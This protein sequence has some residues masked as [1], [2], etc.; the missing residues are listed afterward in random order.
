MHDAD[1]QCAVIESILQTQRG[2]LQFDENGGIDYFGTVLQNPNAIKFWAAQVTS[3]I[4]EL[5][6]V[7]SVEDFQYRFDAATSTLYWSMT[8]INTEDE[9]LDLQQKKTVLDGSPG[10]DVDWNNIYDKP[11]GTNEALAMIA[12]MRDEAQNLD[13]LNASSTLAK[14]KDVIDRVVYDPNDKDYAESRLVRF[15]FAG[16]PLGTVIDFSNMLLDLQDTGGRFVPFTVEISDGTKRRSLTNMDGSDLRAEGNN[17]WFIDETAEP[18]SEGHFPPTQ[19]HTIMSGG[20]VSITI[21]GNITGIKSADKTRPIFL[22]SDGSVFPYLSKFIVGERVPLIALGD[23]AFKGFKNL[24][25]ITWNEPDKSTYEISFGESTFEGCESLLGLSWLPYRL[26]TIGAKCFM[27]CKGI[28]GLSSVLKDKD[29]DN[30]TY[31]RGLSTTLVEAIPDSAFEGC[32]ALGSV[33]YLPPAI[34]SLGNRAFAKCSSLLDIDALPDTIKSLGVECFADCTGIQKILYMPTSLTAIGNGCFSGCTSLRSLFLPKDVAN[35]GSDAFAGDTSL[36]NVMCE[37]ETAPVIDESTFDQEKLDIY[38]PEGSLGRYKVANGW[39][40][41]WDDSTD[42]GTIYEYGTAEFRLDNVTAGTKL[43]AGTSS[44]VSDSIWSVEFRGTGTRPQRF[45]STV[46]AIPAFTFDEQPNDGITEGTAV[47]VV[48]GFIRRMSALTES[49]Y[50]MLAVSGKNSYLTE[51][52]LHLRTSLERIGD[53]AFAEC[54]NLKTVTTDSSTLPFCLGE[55][56]FWGCSSLTSMEWV[57]AFPN[58]GTLPESVETVY[59]L[60]EDGNIQY[61]DQGQP[62]TH[63]EYTYYPAFGEGCFCESGITALSYPTAHV[64]SLSANCFA[65]TK[66]ESLSGIESSVLTSIGEY[67]FNG[68]ENLNSIASLVNT[69]VTTIPA[70]CFADCTALENLDGIDNIAEIQKYAFRGCT[71]LSTIEA[72]SNAS[73]LS[74]LPAHCFEDCTSITTLKGIEKIVQLGEYTFAGCAGL[75]NLNWLEYASR[76]VDGEAV[77]L[78]TIPP[79]CFERCTGI[80]TLVGCYLVKDISEGAFADCTG[81]LSPSGLGPSIASIGERAFQ[82]CT[83]LQF[84][85][86]IA[87]SVPPLGSSAF[88]GVPVSSLTL[89]VRDGMENSFSGWGGFGNV[90]SRTIRV[91]Y[92]NLDGTSLNPSTVDY[93]KVTT[94]IKDGDSTIPG[95]WFIDYGDGTDIIKL[96]EI[97]GDETNPM[98]DKLVSHSYSARGA[99]DITLFGD[100]VD[101]RGADVSYSETAHSDLTSV[102]VPSFLYPIRQNA[103]SVYVSSPYLPKIG[104]FCYNGYGRSGAGLSVSVNIASNGTIGAYAFA[105][106]GAAIGTVVSCNATTIEP[107]AFYGSGLDSSSAFNFVI[108]T[109]KGAF[110]NNTGLP[111]LQGFSALQTLG[112]RTFEGCTALTTTTG[113]SSV[114]TI[115]ARAFSGCTGLVTVRDF[116]GSLTTIKES[117]FAGCE[118]ITTIFMALEN[119][120]TSDGKKWNAGGELAGD[121]FTDGVFDNALLYVPVETES[122]YAGTPAWKRFNSDAADGQ[123]RIRSRSVVF[124][125]KNITNGDTIPK[126]ACKVTATGSWTV[127][128]GSQQT[129]TYTAGTD[130]PVYA[131]T[132]NSPGTEDGSIDVKISGAVISIRG[133]KSQ[134]IFGDS[135]G[136]KLQSISSSSAMELATIGEGSFLN[137]D[138]LK[139]VTTA[140]SVQTLGE[141]AFMGAI[142]LT[143][144]SGLSGVSEIG[145][146]AFSGCSALTSLYGLSSV[147]TIGEYAF[148]GC[149]SLKKIDG[150][151]MGVTSIGEYAFRSCSSLEEIQM[152]AE[153]PPSIAATAFDDFTLPLYVRTKVIPEYSSAAVWSGFANI[154]SRYVEFTLTA[155]PANLTVAGEVGKIQSDTYWVVDWDSYNAD[156]QDSRSGEV[157]FLPE[158]VYTLSGNHTFRIEGAVTSISGD[159]DEEND[160]I[161]NEPTGE[162]EITGKSF[163]TLMLD[164]TEVTSTDHY[165]TRV[166]RSG[167]STLNTV[168]NAAFLHNE[169]LVVADLDGINQ[170][171]ASAFAFS[172]IEDLVLLESVNSI[173]NYAFYRCQGFHNVTNLG[174]ESITIGEYSFGRIGTTEEPL[175]YI[176]IS[177][178]QAGN[179]TIVSKSYGADGRETSFGYFASKEDQEKVSVY[180]PMDSIQS[181]KDENPDNPWQYFTISSQVIEFTL[182][183]VPSGTTIIGLS[184]TD[185]VGTARV[186]SESAWTIDWGD[187]TRDSMTREDTS[188]PA[189]TY[190]FTEENA[191]YW[192]TRIVDGT[193]TRVL[194]SIVISISGSIKFLGCQSVNNAP[195]LATAR[196]VGNPCL[197]KIVASESMEALTTIGDYAF[198]R[199]EALESISGFVHV[200]TIGKFAFQGCTNLV[201]VGDSNS[202]F[203]S[204][205]AVGNQA[206]ADCTSLSS[207]VAFPKVLSI[208]IRSFAN[209]LSLAGTEGLGSAYAGT[210]YQSKYNYAVGDDV[211]AKDWYQTG[212]TDYQ[213]SEITDLVQEVMGWMIWNRITVT[214]GRISQVVWSSNPNLSATFAAYAFEGCD[215]GFIDMN[216]YA[217]PPSIQNTTFSGNP[218]DV[219][220][221]VQPNSL[222]LYKAAPVWQKYWENIIA[223][224]PITITFGAGQITAGKAIDGSNGRIYFDNSYVVIDWGDGTTTKSTTESSDPDNGWVFPNHIY[225]TNLTSTGAVTIRIRGKI[226]SIKTADPTK[227]FISVATYEERSS[228]QYLEYSEGASYERGEVFTVG[229]SNVRYKCLLDISSEDNTSLAAL[230]EANMVEVTDESPTVLNSGDSASVVDNTITYEIGAPIPDVNISVLSFGQGSFLESIGEGCFIGCNIGRVYFGKPTGDTATSIGNN[231]FEGCNKTSEITADEGAISDIGEAAFKG[232]TDLTS[233]GFIKEGC[234]S[235]GVSAFEGCTSIT[236]IN[237]P[238]TLLS[239][240]ERAFYGCSGICY[241]ITWKESEDLAILGNENITIGSQ[242][243]YECTGVNNE[244]WSVFIPSQ[245][246]SIGSSA[247]EKCGMASVQWST[248]HSTGSYQ[249]VSDSSNTFADCPNLK[250]VIGVLPN[251]P[252]IPNYA[253]Y[254]CSQLSDTAFIPASVES[255]GVSSFE[256]CSL[257]EGIFLPADSSLTTIG[258][259]CFRNCMR[260]VNDNAAGGT[261]DLSNA[262]KLTTIYSDS[263]EGCGETYLKLPASENQL[264]IPD[265]AFSYHTNLKGVSWDVGS[266]TP[267]VGEHCFEG[268]DL[269]MTVDSFGGITTL[270][271]HC[272]FLCRALVNI[273]EILAH[274]EGKIGSYCFAGCTSLGNVTI[275]APVIRLDEGCFN[276]SSE[277][278]LRGIY[279]DDPVPETDEELR[280]CYGSIDGFEN[281]MYLKY[282]GQRVDVWEK[283]EEICYQTDFAG[284]NEITW[285]RYKGSVEYRE[286]SLGAGCFMNCNEMTFSHELRAMTDI[287]SF[288]FYN[289]ASM[290]REDFGLDRFLSDDIVSIGKFSFAH[291]NLTSLAWSGSECRATL[292]PAVFLGCTNLQSLSGL[293]KVFGAIPSALPDAAFYGC[294]SLSDISVLKASVP[295]VSLGNYCFAGCTSIKFDNSQGSV[296][297]VFENITKIGDG[298]FEECIANSGSSTVYVPKKLGYYPYRCFAD[299]PSLSTLVFTYSSTDDSTAQTVALEHDAFAGCTNVW[300]IDLPFPAVAGVVVIGKDDQEHEL[301]DPFPNIGVIQVGSE[302]KK[303]A[304][305]KVPSNFVERYEADTYWSKFR[306]ILESEA[307]IPV[308]KDNIVEMQ[309][310]VPAAGVTL[311]LTGNITI[312]PGEK[313]TIDWGDGFSTELLYDYTNVSHD[314]PA[315]SEPKSYKLGISGAVMSLT[316]QSITT[317]QTYYEPL[318]SSVVDAAT[319]TYENT[320]ISSV[321]ILDQAYNNGGNPIGAYCF[322]NNTALNSVAIAINSIT[323]IAPFTFYGCRNLRTIGFFE[324][325]QGSFENLTS[326]GQQAFRYT[327]LPSLSFLSTATRLTTIGERC[328]YATNITDLTGLP[329]SIT[330][331][332]TGAFSWCSQLTSLSGFDNLTAITEVP[333]QC[334]RGCRSLKNISIMPPNAKTLLKQCFS[335]CLVLSD[336]T[337]LPKRIA[338]IGEA[339]FMNSG[340]TTLAALSEWI[341]APTIG[342]AAFSGTKI[343]TLEGFPS[344]IVDIPKECFKGCTNLTTLANLPANTATIGEACFQDCTSLTAD[345]I[346]KIATLGITSIPARCFSGCSA[347]SMLKLPSNLTA[348]GEE[349]FRGCTSLIDLSGLPPSIESLGVGCF[350]DCTGLGDLSGGRSTNILNDGLSFC[351]NLGGLP[352]DCFRGCINLK[353]VVFANSSNTADFERIPAS[354]LSIGANCFAGCN[355][356]EYIGVSRAVPDSSSYLITYITPT[357]FEFDTIKGNPNFMVQVPAAA[358]GTYEGDNNWAKFGI[359]FDTF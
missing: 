359:E 118:N 285:E 323:S 90:A 228:R 91:H 56:A 37:R 224:S 194:N 306:G 337:T 252:S 291:V 149:A 284:P 239:V 302:S 281:W 245:V 126:G 236:A 84:F 299:N 10:I 141:R 241:G 174:G 340:L 356:I 328:F 155:C 171:G 212:K 145:S 55:R 93:S 82:N 278:F 67:C 261:I 234:R 78:D 251:V 157:H 283:Y 101:V 223:S 21:R 140:P 176:Q 45:E 53:F 233:V 297:D 168:G 231:A 20:V 309:V 47:V 327:A 182:E 235:I 25:T 109:K 296:F 42:T 357:T 138:Q 48:T 196:G 102:S 243:F 18:D 345:G 319:N 104:D 317:D 152:F 115:G 170:I 314:Y 127:S 268:C 94:A 64:E 307:E 200:Q 28:L 40:K 214:D 41:Y 333:V 143:D 144:I 6:F 51:V 221:E 114:Q 154:R 7:S 9:R 238:S 95:V 199:C 279:G 218:S 85:S 329:G 192:T 260:D 58:L 105:K 76:L 358:E 215:F 326:I 351:S 183:N 282:K 73:Q 132:F 1:A 99:Y 301:G 289:C 222:E 258:Q 248:A 62:I 295:V 23:S 124:K 240:C 242:A 217:K 39:K 271:S 153:T 181:Y 33:E 17:I 26:K 273:D 72:I 36:T 169:Q 207:L 343:T 146:Y 338:T 119:P 349:A 266:V 292:S 167:Y 277:L 86:C 150:F 166:V 287:P 318:F 27:S 219:I 88:S 308:G 254:G 116:G 344:S 29:K 216:G 123:S 3:K 265:Y 232:C 280:K 334:F 130:I 54:P 298:C 305:V 341:T 71:S 98:P 244:E 8:V 125:F 290:C 32:T 113:L 19:K 59:D 190:E 180:V 348:I 253:F 225:G 2:E 136:K 259:Q 151:G 203:V 100:I 208:G 122:N 310:D 77:Y 229:D 108:E 197:T 300:E 69:G 96:S 249:F 46:T 4:E 107:F 313:A 350:R 89:Y 164:G 81:L 342:P 52:S 15:E 270:P 209:C 195:F 5:D 226:T 336:L 163:V 57:N 204:A 134:C 22:K 137:C 332:G 206:F 286:G 38:V 79:H 187:G 304:Y 191:A 335:E 205:T 161:K 320:V 110:A 354:V 321:N 293:E 256:G 275:P 352:D 315:S 148:N 237:L 255:L 121:V 87:S 330:S 63:E 75:A 322:Y 83:S 44:I 202:G 13:E 142:A 324:R 274:A 178:P 189:H 211:T 246:H 111:E 14:V 24:Q 325:S 312:A 31:I 230:V 347:I 68:C 160:V 74:A 172:G 61:D 311:T 156:G 179:A 16:V 257:S 50:P 97:E 193:T 288:C 49:S 331:L 165:L 34:V 247:F 227:P 159:Y 267:T 12:D 184:A 175:K 201:G 60:D 112:D 70:Y 276:C 120:P 303:N 135:V 264:S 106:T 186:E 185:T 346:A 11:T 198:Q 66:I 262:T 128:Y 43:L 355:S 131:Y 316:G 173:G 30:T 92:E 80:K 158:H 65:K 339:A 294:S 213:A 210:P 269:L 263:F 272:F 35:V 250:S 139:S 103:T 129:M 220:V 162:N 353:K 117:A 188:F 177:V 147:S 133:D